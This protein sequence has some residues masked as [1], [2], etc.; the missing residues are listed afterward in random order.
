PFDLHVVLGLELLNT[1][2]TEVA[3][4]SNVVGEH[5]QRHW[6]A[7]AA[8]LRQVP[9]LL[10]QPKHPQLSTRNGLASA[11]NALLPPCR[12]RSASISSV[13]QRAWLRSGPE[14]ALLFE[15]GRLRTSRDQRGTDRR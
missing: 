12:M 8:S 14:V 6:L 2:G 13:M 4:G 9:T 3:P 7:H 11:A 15:P 1:H 5:G 10:L